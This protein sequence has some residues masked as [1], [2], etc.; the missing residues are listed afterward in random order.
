M[1][2]RFADG[3][4]AGD[5]LGSCLATFDYN[6]DGRLD[7]LAATTRAAGVDPLI[8]AQQGAVYVFTN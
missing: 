8:N 5:R 4:N 6:N 7:V 1:W 2:Y 3:L